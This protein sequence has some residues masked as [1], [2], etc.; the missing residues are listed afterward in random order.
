RYGSSVGIGE[1]RKVPSLMDRVVIP[2]CGRVTAA[3]ATVRPEPLTTTRPRTIPVTSAAGLAGAVGRADPAH[4]AGTPS[5]PPTSNAR[6]V[7][8]HAHMLD[9]SAVR[10]VGLFLTPKP[11]RCR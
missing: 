4:T 8:R 2:Y 11:S 10:P 6:A 5:M 7:R 3:P 1:K 9:G